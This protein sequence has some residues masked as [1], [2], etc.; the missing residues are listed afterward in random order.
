MDAGAR[1]VPTS[2]GAARVRQTWE[3]KMTFELALFLT[4]GLLMFIIIMSD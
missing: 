1:T 4:G 3:V 2:Q